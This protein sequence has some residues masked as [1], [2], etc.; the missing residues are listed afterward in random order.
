MALAGR[1][2]SSKLLVTVII[3]AFI[4]VLFMQTWVF[5]AESKAHSPQMPAHEPFAKKPVQEGSNNPTR[6]PAVRNDNAGQ[7]SKDKPLAD[8]SVQEAPKGPSRKAA[9]REVPVEEETVRKRV[10]KKP[11]QAAAIRQEPRQRRSVE[12]KNIDK[13]SADDHMVSDLAEAVR[14]QLIYAIDTPK[15]RYA[16][17]VPP[18]NG[19]TYHF[20]LLYRIAGIEDYESTPVVHDN[21]NKAGL[22]IERFSPVEIRDWLEDDAVPKY[23]IV[24]N[25]MM[26]TLSA[27]L[28]KVEPELPPNEQTVDHFENW[29]MQEFPKGK[30]TSGKRPKT[31]PH[32]M[33]QTEFCG[34]R[35]NLHSK[36]RV[37]HFEEPQDYVDYI[38]DIIPREFLDD[39]WRRRDTVS[40]KEFMLGPKTRTAGTSSKFSKY[41]RSLKIFDH[42]AGELRRDT[43]VFGYEKEV[44]SLRKQVLYSSS[45]G[46]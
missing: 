42:L 30:M 19:C 31:N 12:N 39:G 45:L 38:Y 16:C 33:P 5:S 4:C 35:A 10:T 14:R 24:R 32:W 46:N 3:V 29:I 21:G 6:N 15:I 13:N 34:V 37:F 23:A 41:F 11:A 26:R 2:I 25:P 20:G 43:E 27:Y 28:D 40:L 22:N 18:K 44:A 1:D 7:K 36:F 9:V 8:N 17:C